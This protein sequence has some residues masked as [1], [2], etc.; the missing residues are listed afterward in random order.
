MYLAAVA[1]MSQVLRQQR[2]AVC[3]AGLSS[4]YKIIGGIVE[5]FYQMIEFNVLFFATHALVAL[6]AAFYVFNEYTSP[7]HDS[8]PT[9]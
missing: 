3:F 4:A 2:W 5:P 1:V 6:M 7:K 8:P 9:D